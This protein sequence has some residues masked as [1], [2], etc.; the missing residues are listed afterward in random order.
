[1]KEPVTSPTQ[2]QRVLDAAADLIVRYGFDKTTM[3][4]IA[5]GAGL[6]K[7]ARYL[8][9]ASKSQLLDALVV[10]QMKRLLQDFQARMEADPDGG[11]LP[12][13]YRH[14][15]LA[16]QAN[17]L[18][19]AL[20]TR[21][22]RMLG[23]FVARQD[24]TRY[25]S[26]MLLSAEAIAQMQA[27]G[28]VQADLSP[29]VITYVLSIIAVGFIH[30]QAIVPTADAPPL[31]AVADAGSHLMQHGLAGQAADSTIGK[32]TLSALVEFA[33]RQYDEAL[34]NTRRS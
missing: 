20:Y 25:T 11:Q 15:L 23:D 31:D 6:S 10:Y 34:S 22:A 14:A 18:M 1:M 5:R 30:I 12:R 7:A 24:V 9:W 32:Q 17:P 21:D 13:L 29:Q 26:R 27:A 4:D 8:I 19:A 16:L 2:T 28:L 33:I 3:E